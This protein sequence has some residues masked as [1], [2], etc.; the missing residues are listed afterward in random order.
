MPQGPEVVR[1]HLVDAERP[2]VHVALEPGE[3]ADEHAAEP[4]EGADHAKVGQHPVD[5]VEV[6]VHVLEEQQR[7]VE[8]GE[9]GRADQALQQG[10]VA[11][12]ERPLGDAAADRDD[13]V[14]PA[15]TSTSAG[16]GSGSSAPAGPGS[17]ST[18]AKWRRLKAG[19]S[20]RAVGPWNATRPARRMTPAS[21]AV[22]SE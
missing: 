14:L 10:E 8:V 7:P 13:A 19:I 15:A 17:A 6:L 1:E 12:R 11:A 16:V 21:S 2:V 4:R 20:A 9:V 3:P 18:R 22:M 5:A